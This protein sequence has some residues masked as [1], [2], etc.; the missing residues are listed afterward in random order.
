MPQRSSTSWHNPREQSLSP[1]HESPA[2][3]LGAAFKRVIVPLYHPNPAISCRDQWAD[4]FLGEHCLSAGSRLYLKPA[5]V[6]PANP[7][8]FSR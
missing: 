6:K 2:I 4:S 1:A 7:H 3:S 5:G 8:P